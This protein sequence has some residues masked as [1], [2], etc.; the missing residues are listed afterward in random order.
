MSPHRVLVTGGAGYIGSHTCLA[1]QEAGLQP[2]VYDD[3]SL[4]HRWAVRFGPL[5]HGHLL[6]QELL[7][8]ALRE[9]GIDAVIHFAAS[10]YVGDSVRDP[11]FY[12]RNNL[13]TTL[14]LMEAMRATGVSTLLFSSSCAVYGDPTR[15]PVDESHPTRPMSPY[16]QTKLDGENA[17]R[18]YAQAYG[19]R[20]AALRYFNAAGADPSGRLGEV[21]DPETRLVPRAIMAALGTLPPLEIFGTDYPTPDGTA[22]RDYI[23]VSDLADAHV[24]GLRHLLAG[25]EGGVLNL[26]TGR[27]YSV[28]EIVAAVETVSGRRVPSVLRP[29]REGDPAEVVADAGRA[30]RSLGW[31]PTASGIESI[32]RTAWRWHSEFKLALPPGD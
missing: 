21:H 15:L 17:I 24:C 2:V 16:G 4:G 9:H 5:V 30:T 18:W 23:H 31:K 8:E 11:A 3:L 29:R 28:H 19:F 14:A 27:G 12:Y 25:G 22:I 6:D 20:W 32:V 26:G 1:L 13:L 7:Q 10:A